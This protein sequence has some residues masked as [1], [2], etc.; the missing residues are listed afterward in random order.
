MTDQKSSW[1]ELAKYPIAVLSVFLALVGGKFILG[2]P[3]GSVSEISTDGVKF[4][5]DAKG[6]I[7]ALS[8]QL[9]AATKS[10]E[11]IKK[12]LPAHTMSAESKS[13]IFE[14]S[15]TV[16]DQTAQIATIKPDG[17]GGKS[18]QT[19]Y[20]WI[21]DYNKA[22]AS[23]QRMK[24]VSPTTNAPLANPPTTI[25]PGTVFSV[26]GNMVLR[27]GLPANDIQYYQARRS[28]GVLPVGTRIKVLSTPVGV[29]R[30]FAIQYW[31]QVAIQP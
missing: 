19:G 6:E 17:G 28:L 26:S 4:T 31:V 10:I 9:N 30:E 13:E 25:A 12:Q 15:Q 14:A 24:L 3:F 2:I 16:S 27:D 11:E 22:A 20:I 23:W 29:D 5:Q 18:E 21:G 8:A 7:A 1:V